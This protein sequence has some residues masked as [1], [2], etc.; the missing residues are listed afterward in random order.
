MAGLGSNREATTWR[1]LRAWR[2][3]SDRLSVVVCPK[4]GARI[5]SLLDGAT[6]R[7]WL[8]QPPGGAP[9]RPLTYGALWSAYEACGW[10]EVFPTIGECAHPG[11]GRAAGRRLPDHGEGWSMAWDDDAGAAVSVTGAALPY[12]MRRTATV[13]DEVLVLGYRVVN[14]GPDP[15]PFQWTTCPR[16]AGEAAVE[17][18]PGW[19]RAVDGESG[20]SLLFE[21]DT[22]ELPFT[23]AE[24]GLVMPATAEG[25]DLE[26]A[27]VAGRALVVP[28]G[29]AASWTLRATL[30]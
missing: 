22:A 24:C 9:L 6:G 20:A 13:K 18:G 19:T 17:S 14:D 7:E 4:R 30:V 12:R 8:V 2:V 1:A 10:D 5:V 3:A 11:P 29:G 23:S 28:A 21:W 27:A 26:V 16:L 25:A 15:L